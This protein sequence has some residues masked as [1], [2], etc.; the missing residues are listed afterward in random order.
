MLCIV[1]MNC[2]ILA[3]SADTY[4]HTTFFGSLPLFIYVYGAII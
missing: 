2:N 3:I 4:Q 1:Y